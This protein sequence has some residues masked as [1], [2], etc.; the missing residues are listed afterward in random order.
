[1]HTDMD[2][3]LCVEFPPS[4]QKSLALPFVG[5]TFGIRAFLIIQ[6]FDIDF[7][8]LFADIP[9]QCFAD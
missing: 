4:Q 1:M 2:I 8:Y 7:V 6:F 9:I 3:V 5:G